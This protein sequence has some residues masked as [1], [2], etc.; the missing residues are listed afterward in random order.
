[1]TR[2]WMCSFNVS[3]YDGMTLIYKRRRWVHLSEAELLIPFSF[4]RGSY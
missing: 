2:C 4:D 3:H 1:M